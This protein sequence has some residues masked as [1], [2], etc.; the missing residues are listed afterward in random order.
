MSCSALPD[1]AFQ[2]KNAEQ[3][4]FEHFGV[5]SLASLGLE[6]RDKRAI[7]AGRVA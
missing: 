6:D 3:A 4:I 2:K 7:A 1:S 5:M